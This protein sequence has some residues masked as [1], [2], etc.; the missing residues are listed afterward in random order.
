LPCDVQAGGLTLWVKRTGDGTQY[1][2]ISAVPS[3]TVAQFKR[4][5]VAS[6]RLDVAPSLVSLRLVKRGPAGLPSAQEEA[7]ALDSPARLFADPSA[8]LAEAGVTDGS[9]LLAAPAS[10]GE[11]ACEGSVSSASLG[12][13][14]TRGA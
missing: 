1:D 4:R 14:T 9:W 11:C 13:A 6:E 12:F 5:W 2:D 8:T 7:D 10:P 3:E